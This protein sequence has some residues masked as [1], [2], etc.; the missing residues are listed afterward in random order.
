[1][2]IDNNQVLSAVLRAGAGAQRRGEACRGSF[3]RGELRVRVG[4]LTH[5]AAICGL[6]ITDRWLG[7]C[8]CEEQIPQCVEW[9]GGY[10]F[11]D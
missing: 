5:V 11:R 1:M 6:V 9:C 3:R 8:C 2:D 7:V 10:E 4:I